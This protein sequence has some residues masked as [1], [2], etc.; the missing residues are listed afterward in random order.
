MAERRDSK[1]RI[2]RPGESQ[3][4]DGRYMYR[5]TDFSGKRRAV[6]S[7]TLTDKDFAPKGKKRGI[8]LRAQEKQ[9]EFD[10]LN[11]VVP[12]GNNLRFSALRKRIRLC[13]PG[14][15][16]APAPATKRCSASCVKTL[17]GLVA[18]TR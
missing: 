2:L 4:T 14:C 13:E 15:G 16:A 12:N 7:W 9:I 3:R 17:L 8:S 10:M 1:N 18:S 11:Q 5:Y 6:Y